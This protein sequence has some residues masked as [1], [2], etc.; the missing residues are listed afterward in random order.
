MGVMDLFGILFVLAVLAM[1]LLST[2]FW[3]WMIVD[4]AVHEPRGRNKL[5][6][7]GL[8]VLTHCVGAAIYFFGRRRKRIVEAAKSK[9]GG[10]P[11]IPLQPHVG[12]AGRGASRMRY[13]AW[14]LLCLY[15]Q[16]TPSPRIDPGVVRESIRQ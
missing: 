12:T 7:I 13:L 6:R 3:I 15:A 8:I 14:V 5:D 16:V 4:C 10:A 1:V 9:A 2:G 11:A